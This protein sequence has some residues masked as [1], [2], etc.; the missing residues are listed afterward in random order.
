[1]LPSPR[2]HALVAVL[3]AFAALP[4]VTP[5]GSASAA[6]AKQPPPVVAGTP[7]ARITLV[8]GDTVIYAKDAAGRASVG[9]ELGPGRESQTYQAERDAHGYYVIPADARRY[10]DAGLLDKELFNVDYLAANGYADTATDR[11]PVIVQYQPQV[12][13]ADLAGKARSLKG[14]EDTLVL[15]SIDGAALKVD[16]KQAGSFWQTVS[17]KASLEARLKADRPALGGGLRKVWLDGKVKALDDVSGPQIGAPE[18][19]AAGYDGTG[20]TV[21]IIDTGI[22]AKHPDLQG[23]VVAAHNFIPAG[24]PGGGDPE[25]PAD[26]HGHGTHVASIIAGSGAASGGRYKGVAPGTKLSIA[27]ALDD[28]GSGTNSEIISAMQWQAASQH[29]RVVNMSLGSNTATDGTDPLSQAADELTAEYGTLFVV[30]AGNSGPGRFTVAAPGAADEALT[31]GAVDSTDAIASFSSRGPRLGDFA[32]KPEITAPGVNIIAARA[33]GTSLGEGSS[34]GGGPIDDN[35]TKASGTS[36]A[37]PHVAAAAGI[38][39]AEHPDWTAHQLKDALV[40]TAKPLGLS[41]YEQGSGRLDIGRAVKQQVFADVST[42]S[43]AFTDPYTGQTLT[44][45]ITYRNT[46]KEPVTLALSAALARGGK[47]APSGM[48][49]VTPSSLT[50]PAGGTATAELTVEPTLGEPGWYEGRLAATGGDATVTIPLAFHK[51]AEQDTL[52]L[53]LVGSPDW[54]MSPQTLSVIRINDTDPALDGEPVAYSIGGVK[55]TDTP[56]TLEAEVRLAHGGLYTVSSQ[57]LWYSEP[58]RRLQFGILFD[59]EIR[60][61]GDAEVTLDATK[62][63]PIRV[64]TPRASIP[65]TMDYMYARTTAAG[66]LYGAAGV[67]SYPNVVPGYLWVSP[68]AKTPTVGAS[69]FVFDQIRRAPQVEL[70]VPGLRLHPAY[71]TEDN[72]VVPKFAA[73][74]RLGLATGEDLRA[75]RDVRGRLVLSGTTTLADLITDM[76][77]AA[78]GGAAGVITANRLAWVMDAAAYHDHMKIPL[79]WLDAG[80]AAQ[81]GTA[82]TRRP[83]L[84]ADLNA[85][86]TAPYEY[87]L[88]YHLKGRVP[89]RMDFSPKENELVGVDTT[90]H[91]QFPAPQGEWGPQRNFLEV[92]H[93]YTRDQTLSIRASHSFTAPATRTEFYNVTGPEVMWERGFT[94]YDFATGEHR[95]ADSFRGFTRP[96]H[97]QEHWNEALIPTQAADGPGLPTVLRPNLYC[98]ACRQGDRL[99]LRTLSAAGLG[100][101]TDAS[102][103]THVYQGASGTEE[104]HL[105]GGDGAE[106]RPQYDDLG[107]PYYTAPAGTA[108]YKLTDVWKDGFAAKHPGTSVESTWTFRTARPASGDAPYPCLDATVWGDKQACGRLPIIHLRYRLGLPQDDTV[109][110]GLPHTFAV[111]PEGGGRTASLKVWTS[112]DHGAHWTAAT[113]LPWLDG[114][115]RA[116][117]RNPSA[118]G[119]VSIRTEAKDT[120]GN[121]VQQTVTDAYLVK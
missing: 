51:E 45:K 23:R 69:T 27:K 20:A 30:A 66:R 52:K 41:P 114:S 78:K 8:T 103:P 29:A 35:Y 49:A 85:Q 105:Y 32:I 82:L 3:A 34:S 61:D 116:V 48:A 99:R 72:A 63:V 83:R 28:T 68:S 87:K 5:P 57:L 37:T 75:G 97:E 24:R 40:G 119:P 10:V 95:D 74:R 44:K 38:L 54:V 109:R 12:K 73:D 17:G 101:Y 13:A 55:T 64:T 43:A 1:M 31:V 94:F 92:D 65:V 21:G 76:D 6:T 111:T 91:A 118:A 2:R 46:G 9:V 70:A 36:M 113:V 108:T 7:Q 60:L 100:Y 81:L 98:D 4:L 102:D 53:R 26:G 25:V 112:A 115:Y 107:L 62:A 67:N 39:A 15:Q 22:D 96:A 71:V 42:V 79:L 56:N 58:E 18:A 80:E 16:K 88:A 86:P 110:A 120:A 59:P 104:V 93:T 90:Y 11:L 117:V 19:W 50:V 106:V 14:G 84:E 47:P 77:L 121:T 33:A 89:Q